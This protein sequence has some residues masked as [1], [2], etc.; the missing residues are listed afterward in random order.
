M[1]TTLTPPTSIL[2]TWRACS[3]T[4][5]W[6]MNNESGAGVLDLAAVFLLSGWVIEEAGSPESFGGVGIKSKR[7]TRSNAELNLPIAKPTWNQWNDVRDSIE[8]G[9][10]RKRVSERV[11]LM[12]V[13]IGWDETQANWDAFLLRLHLSPL[14]LIAS[15]LLPSSA[16]VLCCGLCLGEWRNGF[17]EIIFYILFVKSFIS[18]L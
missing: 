17:W 4:Q 2:E 13:Q 5:S 8:D 14:L 15:S 16:A 3:A 9:G 12:E 1:P 6:S 18:Q 11:P 7:N 10:R